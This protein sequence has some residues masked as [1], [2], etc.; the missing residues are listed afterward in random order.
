MDAMEAI[1][2]RKSIR[3]Y[4]KEAVSKELIDELLSAA[5]NAPSAGNEQPWHFVVIQD[6][7][8]LNEIPKCH[9]NASFLTGAPVVIVVCADLQLQKWKDAWWIQDC[10]AAA[11]NILIAAQAKG[12]GA[13]WA[14]VYPVDRR[15]QGIKDLLGLPQDVIPLC[16]IPIGYPAEKKPSENRYQPSRIHHNHW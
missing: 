14:G 16:I 10:S 11:E 6:L 8:I 12:L 9:P 2:S 4:T 15:V 13:V 3:K 5:M 7:K 1:I